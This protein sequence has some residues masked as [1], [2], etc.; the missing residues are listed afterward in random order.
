MRIP[1]KSLP[2][3]CGSRLQPRNM[4]RVSWIFSCSVETIKVAIGGVGIELQQG[5]RQD[6]HSVRSA[7]GYAA[8]TENK[9]AL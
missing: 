9:S 4:L 7:L 2:L 1:P 6:G 5:P 8:L 3:E